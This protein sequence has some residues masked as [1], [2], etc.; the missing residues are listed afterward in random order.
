[1]NYGDYFVKLESFLL[2]I[3]HNKSPFALLNMDSNNMFNMH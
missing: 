2:H 1:M 3:L